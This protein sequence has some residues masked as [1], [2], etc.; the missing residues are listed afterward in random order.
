MSTPQVGQFLA[1]EEITPQN[2]NQIREQIQEDLK[3]KSLSPSISEDK[4]EEQCT[5]E[6]VLEQLDA[7]KRIKEA[8]KVPPKSLKETKE[9]LTNFH[10]KMADYPK[11]LSYEGSMVLCV[12]LAMKR[13]ATVNI[14]N[15]PVAD[16]KLIREL[17][18]TKGV[19]MESFT[20][21]FDVRFDNNR[22]FV[23]IFNPQ[24]N[25]DLTINVFNTVA[26]PSAVDIMKREEVRVEN[27]GEKIAVGGGR[28]VLN[29]RDSQ[30]LAGID[31]SP[32]QYASEEKEY[33]PSPKSGRN[34][35]EIRA[36]VLQMAIHWAQTEDG[37]GQYKK[38]SDD[39]VVALAKKFYAFVENKR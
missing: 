19:S 15:M 35:Y 25:S 26:H 10:K 31:P 12:L 1:N 9:L 3:S 6:E 11:R 2:I 14:G 34:A 20:G 27:D 16:Q 21:N 29:K 13:V 33:A 39:D 17:I 38:P 8:P 28:I 4:T 5:V 37:F 30:K 7:E 22:D 36:D 23:L 32:K 24:D 18:G